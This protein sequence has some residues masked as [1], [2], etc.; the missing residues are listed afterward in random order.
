MVDSRPLSFCHDGA[1]G[2]GEGHERE[3]RPGADETSFKHKCH[4]PKQRWTA[5]PKHYWSPLSR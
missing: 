5:K 1:D 2:R 4:Q 3:R